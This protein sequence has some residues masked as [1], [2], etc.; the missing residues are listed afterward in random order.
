MSKSECGARNAQCG[1]RNA[2][3]GVR[4][5][6]LGIW[7]VLAVCMTVWSSVVA[8]EPNVTEV[9]AKITSQARAALVDIELFLRIPTDEEGAGASGAGETVASQ[10]QDRQQDQVARDK[11]AVEFMGVIV[12]PREVLVPDTGIDPRRI[13]RWEILDSTSRRTTVRRSSFLLDAPALVL[14]P[15]DDQV[16][17]AVPEF[18]DAAI[19][20]STSL[21]LVT[22]QRVQS[23]WMLNT[24][25]VRALTR[26][27]PDRDGDMDITPFW[28]VGSLTSGAPSSDALFGGGPRASAAN[29]IFTASG[30]LLGAGLADRIYADRPTP[31]WRGADLRTAAR[32][33]ETEWKEIQDRVRRGFDAMSYPVRIEY[34][35]PKGGSQAYPD[36]EL[37]GW[38]VSGRSLVIPHAIHRT[39]AAQIARITIQVSGRDVEGQ[40]FGQ[41]KDLDAFLV[42]LDRDSEPLPSYSD[43]KQAGNVTVYRPHIA[44]TMNRKYGANDVRVDYTRKLGMTRGYGNRLLPQFLPPP[45]LGSLVMDLDGKPVGYFSRRRRPM[46]ELE[47]YEQTQSSQGRI[48][49]PTSNA[50]LFALADWASVLDNP[51]SYFD[52]RVVRRDEKDQDRRVWLGIEFNPLS[53]DLAESLGCRK[54]SKDGTVGLMINQIY[55]GSPAEQ[56]GLR[57]SDVLMSVEVP[58]RPKSIDLIPPRGG[59]GGSPDFSQFRRGGDGEF[60]G[61]GPTRAPWPSRNN[62]LTN[63]LAIVGADT[64]V[65]FNFWRGGKIEQV[66]AQIAQAPPDQDSAAQFKDEGLGITVKEITYEVRA[67]L[68]LNS[69]D[70]GVIVAKVESGSPAGR[71]RIN[72]FEIVQAADGEPIKSLAEFESLIKKAQE[73]KKDQMR[74]TIVDRGRSRFADLKLGQ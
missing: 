71:A 3:S 65:R 12:S 42:G 41:L 63:L 58:G 66:E 59:R 36:S 35:R 40:F 69:D 70:P 27:A 13:D 46:E 60:G 56:I 38:A 64:S 50:E 73:E 30:Q 21:V 45:P 24:S 72:P 67:A 16:K 44:M 4:P 26:W 10:L 9:R 51:T 47:P 25:T 5:G 1:T 57:T 43:L 53:R 22:P 34:R 37:L 19:D 52:P 33:S 20:P 74:L 14:E 31:P 18:A 17:W 15:S 6:I 62:Y 8:Q 32:M 55:A 23:E 39:I 68:R 49:T 28:V 7:F 11:K 54:E 2:T 48:Q 61:Q 29:L